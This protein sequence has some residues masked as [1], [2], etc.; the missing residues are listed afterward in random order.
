MTTTYRHK[1]WR[2][3]LAVLFFSSCKKQIE[4]P[5]PAISISSAN[6]FTN[7]QTAISVLTGLYIDISKGYNTAGYFAGNSGLSVMLGLS[8]DEL[9]LYDMGSASYNTF[10]S[11]I[12]ASDRQGIN[13]WSPLYAYI[14]RCNSA[15]EGLND[16][17]AEALTPFIRK[18]LLG[19]AT[20]MRAFFYFYLTSMY[21]DLPLALTTDYKVNTLLARSPQTQICQQIITDLKAAIELLAV[22]Y[23]DVTLLK[24][25]T[26]RVRPTQWAARALLARMYLHIGDN[27]NAEHESSA[28]IENTLFSLPTVLNDVFLKTSSEAIWQVQPVTA[29]FNT[30]DARAF[31]LTEFGPTSTADN[32]VYLSQ[33]LLNSFEPGDL[34]HVGKNWVDSIII[35]GITYFFPYKYKDNLYNSSI[36]GIDGPQYMTEYQMMLRL[37]EQY[38]IRAEARAKQNN[39]TGAITDIDMI[40]ERA[41]LPLIIDSN[42]GI[43][44]IALLDAI[45]HERQVELFTEYGHRWFDLKRTGK[46]DEVMSIV[47]PIKSQGTS[48]WETH[49]QF[50]PIP[51]SDLDKAP[52]LTQTNGY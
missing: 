35:G 38:L 17:S 12:F 39:L 36:T 4:I 29:F 50:F 8:A 49:Q 9:T 24:T 45:L 37:A 22:E 43:S 46:V 15:I 18:Q 13:Y 3:I 6:V 7:D 10:Y 33:S 51:K 52:N 21:G 41:G 30:D 1:I 16:P 19:E 26:E 44:Q 20:F 48:Q 14:F 28:I 25:T 47:T 40:R 11:N 32:P 34:R 5:P 2:F 27:A 31:V 23:P 42:P